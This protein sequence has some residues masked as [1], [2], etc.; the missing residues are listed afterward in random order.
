MSGKILSFRFTPV[1]DF[2]PHEHEI[3]PAPLPPGAW[4]RDHRAGGAVTELRYFIFEKISF[5]ATI[6]ERRDVISAQPAHF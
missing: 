1:F 2:F 4:R 5:M 3:Q 6:T